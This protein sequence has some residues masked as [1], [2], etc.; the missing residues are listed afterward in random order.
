MTSKENRPQRIREALG[1]AA[2]WVPMGALVLSIRVAERW[3]RHR[4]LAL[5]KAGVTDPPSLLKELEG[6]G[7]PQERSDAFKKLHT[8]LQD[9]FNELSAW[10]CGLETVRPGDNSVI[11]NAPA[12]SWYYGDFSYLFLYDPREGKAGEMYEIG[13][14]THLG[15]EGEHDEYAVT[16]YARQN[17][18][19]SRDSSWFSVSKSS[20]DAGSPQVPLSYYHRS[21]DKLNDAL[22]TGELFK[23]PPAALYCVSLIAAGGHMMSASSA[24]EFSEILPHL[25]PVRY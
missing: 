12:G 18:D 16:H 4:E 5:L 14:H 15:H 1:N 2:A 20:W 13:K 21:G 11:D 3:G 9:R 10:Q 25:S 19:G 23:K 24:Q 17:P 7:T 22:L 6:L 8:S